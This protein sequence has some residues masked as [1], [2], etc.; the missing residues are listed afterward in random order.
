[1]VIC[2][3]P[4]SSYCRASLIT[5]PSRVFLILKFPLSSCSRT[6]LSLHVYLSLFLLQNIS[7][8]Q[9]VV[10]CVTVL[11]LVSCGIYS[12]LQRLCGLR[13]PVS[14]SHPAQSRLSPYSSHVSLLNQLLIQLINPSHS[15]DCPLRV[16]TTRKCAL[17]V[18]S[19]SGFFG[20]LGLSRSRSHKTSVLSVLPCLSEPRFH[21]SSA[22]QKL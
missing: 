7:T 11:V 2:L 15:S 3:G 9:I 14:K 13:P 6:F 21:C 20:L 17:S 10:S 8:L 19:V 22:P 18:L 4:L 16:L 5:I 12:T 1:M